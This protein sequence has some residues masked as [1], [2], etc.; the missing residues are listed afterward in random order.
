MYLL[1]FIILR[2]IG[3]LFV[4]TTPFYLNS[5]MT[6]PKCAVG[7]EVCYVLTAEPVLLCGAI[8]IVVCGFVR[9]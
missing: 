6:I 8:D 7:A 3:Y 2:R 9:V 1:Y 4:D 5:T